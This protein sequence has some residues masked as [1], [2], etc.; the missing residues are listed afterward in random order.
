MKKNLIILL[1]GFCFLFPSLA[2]SQPDKFFERFLGPML[3]PG[4]LKVLQLEMNPDPVG[5]GA[6]VEFSGGRL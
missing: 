5:G 3:Q 2:Q 1:L 6:V 4:D